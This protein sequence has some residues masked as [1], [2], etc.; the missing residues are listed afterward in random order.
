MQGKE[1]WPA[2]SHFLPQRF[3][4]CAL[5]PRALAARYE[6]K[7]FPSSSRIRLHGRDVDRG[8][9]GGVRPLPRG[10]RNR[11][12]ISLGAHARPTQPRYRRDRARARHRALHPRRTAALG[13]ARG[14]VPHH[15]LPL[16]L[17]ARAR[18]DCSGPISAPSRRRVRRPACAQRGIFQAHRR[19]E[20]HHGA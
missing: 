14:G 6:P 18:F 19:A 4:A 9:P 16:A 13:P 20:L 5:S 2:L 3:T 8:E 11:A 15:R 7:L 12:C 1:P 10:V 17:G